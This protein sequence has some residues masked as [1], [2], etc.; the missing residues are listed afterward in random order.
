MKLYHLVAV[1]KNG[2]IGLDNDIPWYISAD[3]KRFASITKGCSIVMGRKTFE[4]IGKALPGRQNVVLTSQPEK[5]P[6]TVDGATSINEA[7]HLCEN[8]EVFIIGGESVYRETM[9]RVDELRITHVYL[10][11]KGDTYYPIDEVRE[12][13][14]PYY[15][16][17]QR[18]V[19]HGEDDYGR[20]LVLAYQFVD[21]FRAEGLE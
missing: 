16:S 12:N 9:D 10:E 17:G 21:Y 3:L 6:E 20:R 4:S 14:K 7:L 15:R 5:L 19:E 11:P 8:E 13:W 2:V 1:A 18:Q